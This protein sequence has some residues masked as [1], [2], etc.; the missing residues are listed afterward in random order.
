MMTILLALRSD[1]LARGSLRWH[2]GRAYPA[3][4][5]ETFDNSPPLERRFASQLPWRAVARGD[6]LEVT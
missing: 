6:S 5:P 3:Y 4:Y 1:G 2:R